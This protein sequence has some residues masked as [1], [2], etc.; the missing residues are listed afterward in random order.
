MIILD[1][2]FWKKANLKDENFFVEIALTLYFSKR[3][4]LSQASNI[5]KISKDE[6]KLLIKEK[7]NLNIMLNKDLEETEKK[8]ENGDND[9]K[10]WFLDALKKLKGT[11]VFSAIEDPI[12]LQIALRNEW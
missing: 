5:A 10:F 1:S 8:V 7:C 3:V 12:K 11:S 6:F 2:E 9:K 4:S